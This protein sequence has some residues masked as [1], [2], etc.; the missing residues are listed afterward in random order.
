M[1]DGRYTPPARCADRSCRSRTFVPDR[2]S[3]R[4]IDFQKIRLQELLG[5]DQQQQ[6]KVPRSVEVGYQP[7]QH[8]DTLLQSNPAPDLLHAAAPPCLPVAVKDLLA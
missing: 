4:C 3:A 8:I 5:A 6:G 1:P 2:D 7:S